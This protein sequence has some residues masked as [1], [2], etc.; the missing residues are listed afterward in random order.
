MANTKRQKKYNPHRH[1]REFGSIKLALGM[2]LLTPTDD[3]DLLDQPRE[4]YA[5]LLAGKLC[6]NGFVRLSEIAV[7]AYMAGK[8]LIE[9]GASLGTQ[10]LGGTYRMTGKLAVQSLEEI[11]IHQG[12][13]GRFV[14]TADQY[15]NISDVLDM[16]AAVIPVLTRGELVTVLHE[17]AQVVEEGLA[18]A[19]LKNEMKL[20]A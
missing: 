15:R 7:A 16:L 9:R 1:R 13:T 11:G 18:Q 4:D 5:A 8:L 10:E 20:A 19:R 2:A 17:A 14:G 12:K 3:V 6:V